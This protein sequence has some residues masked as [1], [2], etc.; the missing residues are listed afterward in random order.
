MAVD[1][2]LTSGMQHTITE[3][4]KC[5]HIPHDLAETLSRY[6]SMSLVNQESAKAEKIVPIPFKLV[7][8]LWECLRE[9]QTTDSGSKMYLHELLAG[10]EVYV[11]PLKLP[12]KSPELVARLK[13]LKAEQEKAEYDRMVSNVNKKWDQS[14][15]MQFGQEVRSGSKQLASIINFLLS[16]VGTFVF[17]Y[18]A[19]QY[20]FP[21]VAVRVIIGIVLAVVVAIAELYFMARVEI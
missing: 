21:S 19:S 17:G 4:I 8:Q 20:A 1:V 6:T 9:K 12:E 13:K 2:V 18:I 14:D 16:V 3:A 10:S 15:G 11:E 5:H 7:K